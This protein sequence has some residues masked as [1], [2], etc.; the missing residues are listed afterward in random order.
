MK[1][2]KALMICSALTLSMGTAIALSSPKMMPIYAEGEPEISEPA[3]NEEQP[4]VEQ[5]EQ[6]KDAKEEINE[7]LDKWLSPQMVALYFSWLAYLGTIIGLVAN[8]KKLKQTN[9]LTLKNVSEEVKALIKEVIGE[10]VAEQF[11]KVAPQLI[12]G[13]DNANHIMSIFA[14]ILALSQD[15]SPEAK[16]AILNLIEELGTAGQD[17]VQNAKEAIK[18]SVE[19]EQ[20]TKEA[21]EKRIDDIVEQYDGTSI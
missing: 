13:Q 6:E 21:I 8:I 1:K 20:K 4:V 17:L 9:N 5:E 15:N 11:G 14:K 10:E 2:I 7:F 3:P 12:S 19:L 18:E 16:V